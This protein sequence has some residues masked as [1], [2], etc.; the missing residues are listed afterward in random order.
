MFNKKVV[1]IIILNLNDGSKKFLMYLIGEVIEFVMVK[2]FDE[3]MGLV[4]ML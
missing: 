3:M 1:G 4:S 2:V